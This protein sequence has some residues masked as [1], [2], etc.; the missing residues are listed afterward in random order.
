MKLRK[1]G[2]HAV[3]KSTGATF[4]GNCPV[5]AELCR[6]AGLHVEPVF[7]LRQRGPCPGPGCTH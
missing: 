4:Y 1:S 7:A 6:R 2:F 5:W 3:D